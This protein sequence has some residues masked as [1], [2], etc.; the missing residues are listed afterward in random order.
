MIVG[1]GGIVLHEGRAVHLVALGI[2]LGKEV[3]AVVGI[4]VAHATHAVACLPVN[5]TLRPEEQVSVDIAHGHLFQV[6]GGHQVGGIEL[7]AQQ[8][9]TVAV[10]LHTVLVAETGLAQQRIAQFIDARRGHPD[11]HPAALGKHRTGRI[12]VGRLR[13]AGHLPGSPSERTCLHLQH[14]AHEHAVFSVAV[15]QGYQRGLQAALLAAH[16][17]LCVHLGHLGQGVLGDGQVTG[18]IGRRHLNELRIGDMHL[19]GR[20]GILPR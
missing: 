20:V 14:K 9:T 10:Y 5:G 19:I 13:G 4:M 8:S 6:V 3:I 2:A 11:L 17:H 16:H 15:S 12:A 1:V 7:L 18:D